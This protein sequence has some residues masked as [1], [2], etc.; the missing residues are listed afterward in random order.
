MVTGIETAGYCGAKRISF[1]ITGTPIKKAVV[2]GLAEKEFSYGGVA[3]TPKVSLSLKVKKD[4]VTVDTL[5]REGTDYTV[6]WQK[7][8]E[9][10]TASAIFTGK[11]AY[12]GT[13]KKSFKILPFDLTADKESRVT[14][15]LL[16][17]SV[18]YAKGGAKPAVSL[19]FRRDDGSTQV[20]TEGKD[21]TLTFK[22]HKTLNDG[23]DTEKLPAVTIKGK[24][25]GR[26]SCR[27]RV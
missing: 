20:L 18:P 27:E 19:T 13:M 11:G 26:A 7:N 12:T 10:G 6:D 23:S 17:E 25:I 15:A 1:K 3:V 2:T 5:L 22:N 14:V 4:G 8:R 9:A 21:Y 16:Q 24:E